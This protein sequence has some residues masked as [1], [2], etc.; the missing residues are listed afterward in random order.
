MH[1][2][3]EDD[4][5]LKRIDFSPEIDR[6]DLLLTHIELERWRTSTGWRCQHQWHSHNSD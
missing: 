6:V 5:L 4:K 2:E 1:S 3:V